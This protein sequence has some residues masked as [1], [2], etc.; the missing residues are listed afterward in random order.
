MYE[1]TICPKCGYEEAE[2]ISESTREKYICCMRCGYRESHIFKYSTENGGT[3][4]HKF[5][6]GNGSCIYRAKETVTDI[7]D[8]ADKDTIDNLKATLDEYEY[9]KY[10]FKRGDEWLIKDLIKNTECNFSDEELWDGCEA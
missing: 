9:C 5:L 1:Y 6:G 4:S 2:H 7:I 10:S 3:W 8:S